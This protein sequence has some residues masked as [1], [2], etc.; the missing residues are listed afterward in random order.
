VSHGPAGIEHQFAAQEFHILHSS[1]ETQGI[2]KRR[3]AVEAEAYS[4]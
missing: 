1:A 3:E 2:G 4:Q